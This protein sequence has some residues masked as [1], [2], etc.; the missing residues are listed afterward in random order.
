MT[1]HDVERKEDFFFFHLKMR[2]R[3]KP[4]CQFLVERIHL[5]LHREHMNVAEQINLVSYTLVI[6]I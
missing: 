1:L 5:K 4:Y 3:K 2:K 6:T